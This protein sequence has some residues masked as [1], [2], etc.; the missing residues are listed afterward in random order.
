LISKVD[1]FEFSEF[2]NFFTASQA[3][4]VKA[5]STRK[6]PASMRTFHFAFE[7]RA[8]IG[9][10]LLPVSRARRNGEPNNNK[11]EDCMKFHIS[12]GPCHPINNTPTNM[13]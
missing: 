13:L 9:F 6:I 2:L 3:L 7:R 8:G 1:F 5:L 12:E 4:R 11:A 10:L